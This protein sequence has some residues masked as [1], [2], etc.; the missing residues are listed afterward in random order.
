MDVEVVL[1]FNAILEVLEYG[2][3]IFLIR[4]I[5]QNLACIVRQGA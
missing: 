2:C 1:S 3:E 5:P 4:L